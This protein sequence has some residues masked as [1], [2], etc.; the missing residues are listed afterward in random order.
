[1]TIHQHS[2][3]PLLE[4]GRVESLADTS[5]F[6][7]FCRQHD[8]QG[9]NAQHT[10]G[11]WT[12]AGERPTYCGC[13]CGTAWPCGRTWC[14]CR[15]GASRLRWASQPSTARRPYT[16]GPSWPAN[17]S[18]PQQLCRPPVTSSVAGPSGSATG[19]MGSSYCGGEDRQSIDSWSVPAAVRG[20]YRGERSP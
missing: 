7:Q 14:T 5:P 16:S 19:A 13:P 9:H 8:H 17:C 11:D 4:T 1:M 3:A 6:G 20:V 18:V 12:E 15:G 10:G 2:I